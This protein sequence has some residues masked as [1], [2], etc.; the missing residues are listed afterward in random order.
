M[1][2][3][4]SCHIDEGILEKFN[5]ALMLNKK[6]TTKVIER[7]MVQYISTSFSKTSQEYKH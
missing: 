4:F 2:N 7:Y 6:E 1:G 5:L 3:L